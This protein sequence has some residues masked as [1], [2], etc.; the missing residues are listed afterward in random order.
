VTEPA[1][2][3]ECWRR[4]EGVFASVAQDLRGCNPALWLKSGWRSSQQSPFDAWAEFVRV[5]DPDR[6]EDIVVFVA[7]TSDEDGF[8]A[9]VDIA[10]G[11]GVV[12][13]DGPTRMLPPEPSAAAVPAMLSYVADVQRFLADHHRVLREALC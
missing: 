4:L 1:D 8:R 9:S 12:L 7:V 10:T 5:K 13:A 2:W 6:I 3:D 11:E